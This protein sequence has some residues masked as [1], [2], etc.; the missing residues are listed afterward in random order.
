MYFRD[1]SF[2]FSLPLLLLSLY[3]LLLTLIL[4]A[5]QVQT[6]VQNTVINVTAPFDVFSGNW[7]LNLLLFGV[8]ILLAYAIATG[9]K[10]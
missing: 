10:Q 8:A 3:L 1:T 9:P 5:M 6:G 4:G 7:T 2:L